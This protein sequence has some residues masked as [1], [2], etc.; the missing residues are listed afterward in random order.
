MKK[1]MIATVLGLALMPLTFAAQTPA[2][3][4]DKPASTSS[5]TTDTTK[6]V[7]KHKKHSKKPA[8]AV[9]TPANNA[10]PANKP[11]ATPSK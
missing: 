7:K 5:S 8:A 3:P 1:T 6:P 4:A 10:V 2:K 11:A 9:K